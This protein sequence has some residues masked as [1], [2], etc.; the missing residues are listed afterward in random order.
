MPINYVYEFTAFNHEG[1][2]DIRDV[3]IFLH[4]IN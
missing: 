4:I 1:A 2:V 3:R